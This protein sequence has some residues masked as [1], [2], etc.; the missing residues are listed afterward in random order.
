MRSR[1]VLVVHLL[2]LA[3]AAFASGESVQ[4]VSLTEYKAQL[5]SWSSAVDNLS[6]HPETLPG[7]RSSIPPTLEVEDHGERFRCNNDWLRNALTDILRAPSQNR[8][9]RITQVQTRLRE[10]GDAADAF[11]QPSPAGTAEGERLREILSRREFRLVH[12]P[13]ELE[14]LRDRVL[15]WIFKVLDKMM[16]GVAAPNQAGQAAVWVLIAAGLSVL[17]IWMKRRLTQQE[18]EVEREIMAFAAV[19][20]KSWRRW[21]REAEAAAQA[22]DWRNAI[23]ALYWATISRLEES[24]AWIPDR[25]RTPREYLGFLPAGA[26]NRSALARITEVF[27]VVWYGS[28]SADAQVF[29]QAQTHFRSLPWR[30]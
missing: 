6:A 22:G 8:A 13:G 14:K 7:L 3:A 10:M 9:G 28:R 24:G 2:V 15:E 5:Q 29:Q 19:S 27:E 18:H 23:H 26:A 11:A 1:P 21:V 16:R 17:A 12:G 30:T 25:A 20:S 4:P